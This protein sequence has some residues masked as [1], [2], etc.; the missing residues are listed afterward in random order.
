M[1]EDYFK[2]RNLFEALFHHQLFRNHEIDLSG[3]YNLQRGD[4]SNKDFI[5]SLRYTLRMN[6]PVQKI[7]EYTTLSGNI[8]N[9]GVKK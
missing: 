4:L 7:A 5:V 8:S 3:R 9:L 2:D 6:V 1:P